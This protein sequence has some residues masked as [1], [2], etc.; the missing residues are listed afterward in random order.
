MWA[1]EWCQIIMFFWQILAMNLCLIGLKWMYVT[2]SFVFVLVHISTHRTAYSPIH[3]HIHT[4]VAATPL[5]SA[6]C[7]SESESFTH[8]RSVGAASQ[9]PGDSLQSISTS[10]LEPWLY[11][12][13]DDCCKN[14][15][16]WLIVLYTICI[17]AKNNNHWRF[18]PSTAF[19]SIFKGLPR[20]PRDT[21]GIGRCRNAWKPVR[22]AWMWTALSQCC[23]WLSVTE[24]WV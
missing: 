18:L 22:I 16:A 21:R 9:K 8:S 14:S 24:K 3:T 10:R 20:Y 6:T 2:F 15:A 23:H 7:S 19:H 1:V 17:N 5:L 12:Y 4:M 13:L 11:H